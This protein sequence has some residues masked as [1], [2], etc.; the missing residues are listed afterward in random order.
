MSAHR[1]FS[2]EL[3]AAAN[4]AAERKIRGALARLNERITDVVVARLTDREMDRTY[5]VEATLEGHV[6]TLRFALAFMRQYGSLQLGEREE[7]ALRAADAPLRRPGTTR[8]S[9]SATV[10]PAPAEVRALPAPK[11][12]GRKSA[13]TTPDRVINLG[14]RRQ[15]LLPAAR[16]TPDEET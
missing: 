13:A 7:A 8:S 11:P 15:L 12:R 5:D 6:F 9:S 10:T 14:G 4:K 3:Q 16:P 2:A 1:S